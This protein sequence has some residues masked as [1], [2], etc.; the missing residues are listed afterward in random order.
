MQTEAESSCVSVFGHCFHLGLSLVVPTNHPIA[1]INKETAAVLGYIIFDPTGV[2]MI[3]MSSESKRDGF[4]GTSNPLEQHPGF[5]GAARSPGCLGLDGVG[6]QRWRVSHLPTCGSV[7][8]QASLQGVRAEQWPSAAQ[9]SRQCSAQA[10][11]SQP[12]SKVRCIAR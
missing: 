4:L 8:R 9:I 3:A 12:I 7:V 10:S 6:L 1:M 11:H 5:D 2:Q